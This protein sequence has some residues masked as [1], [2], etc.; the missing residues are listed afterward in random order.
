MLIGLE[1]KT[2]KRFLNSAIPR[3]LGRISYSL[4]LVH[5]TVLYGLT[6]VVVHRLTVAPR[7]TAAEVFV[8]FL[9]LTLLVSTGFC[10]WIEEPFVRLGRRLSRAGA[11]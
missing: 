1:S 4:Y 11:V 2:A 6:F 10:L 9:P 5:A 3:F 7:V 8:I